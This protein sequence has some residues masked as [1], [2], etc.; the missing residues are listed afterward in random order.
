MMAALTFI[1]PA[2]LGIAAEQQWAT[3]LL[4]AAFGSLVLVRNSPAWA[5][6]PLLIT[7]LTLSSYMIMQFGVSLRLATALAAVLVTAQA[8]L[9]LKGFRDPTGRRILLP[10]I[11]FIILATAVNLGFSD[12]DY[13]VKYFRYQITQLLTLLVILAVVRTRLDLKR[14]AMVALILAILGGF[15]AVWQHYGPQ[16]APYGAADAGAI[17]DFK[18]RAVGLSSNPVILSNQLAFVLMPLLG[19]LICG[20]WKR[21][22]I[23]AIL[24]FS[25]LVIGVGLNFTYTRSAVFGM[26][27]GLIVMGLYLRG[28]RRMAVLGSVIAIVI[29]FQLLEGT[30]LIGDRYYKD[31]EDDQSAASHEVLWDVGLAVAMDNPIVGIGHEHF[32]EVSRDYLHVLDRAVTTSSTTNGAAVIGNQQPHNDFL[33]V[34]LSWG[35]FA[36]IAYVAIFIGTLRN[37]AGPST[38]ADPLIRGLAVGCAGGVI[39]YAVNSAYHNYLDSGTALW[40]YAG[41]SVVLARLAA[42]RPDGGWSPYAARYAAR[43]LNQA[44]NGSVPWRNHA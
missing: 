32:I 7:E 27:P 31:A 8:V 3:L 36:L 34:W 42:R 33:S 30:G 14:L 29:M 15:A 21:D 4:G 13:V 10:T 6:V 28:T 24:C 19:V 39:T 18:G 44:A 40:M 5:V 16:T 2:G 38:H 41:L 12:S 23:R 35:I 9:R 25:T 26:G 17:K 20:P 1:I 11:A 37:C 43:P 22:R